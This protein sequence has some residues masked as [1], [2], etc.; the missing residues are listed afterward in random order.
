MRTKNIFEDTLRA[1]TFAARNFRE[2]KKSRDIANL[3]FANHNFDRNFTN[4]SFANSL[5]YTIFETK[6]LKTGKYLTNRG[7]GG[8]KVILHEKNFRVFQI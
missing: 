8:K 2:V 6:T 1:K 5:K 3:S 7:K 4:K